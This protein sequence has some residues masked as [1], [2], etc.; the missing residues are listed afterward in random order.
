LRYVVYG[1]LHVGMFT[2]VEADSPEQ[3]RAVAEQRGVVGLCH[4]CGGS[5]EKARREWCVQ[6]WGCGEVEV[7]EDE[8]SVE[9]ASD[10]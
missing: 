9:V 1:T 7:G 5:S 10:A 6:D 4:Q 2:T 3:A 8:E